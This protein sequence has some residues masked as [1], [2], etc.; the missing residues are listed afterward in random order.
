MSAESRQRLRTYVKQRTGRRGYDPDS[1]HALDTG[2]PS[3]T[4]LRL[5]DIRAMIDAN[6]RYRKALEEIRERC[7]HWLAGDDPAGLAEAVG[8]ARAIADEVLKDEE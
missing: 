4:E 3:E 1:I 8:A 2:A 5:S 7:S 6:D